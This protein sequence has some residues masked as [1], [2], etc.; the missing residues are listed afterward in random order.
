M[1]LLEYRHLEETEV[2]CALKFNVDMVF[3]MVVRLFT[4]KLAQSLP[5]YF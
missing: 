2:D 1:R 5:G 3:T 4:Q